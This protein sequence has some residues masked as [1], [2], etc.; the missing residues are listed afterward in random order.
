MITFPVSFSESKVRFDVGF[1]H[2]D[3]FDVSFGE[4]SYIPTTEI[5]SGSYEITPMVTS[6]EIPTAEKY[7]KYDMTI[8]AIP[9]FDVSNTAGGSTVYIG[10]EIE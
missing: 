2:N 5:Y 7:M 3:G 6:Q 8:N 1:E 4:L 9:Y 10:K